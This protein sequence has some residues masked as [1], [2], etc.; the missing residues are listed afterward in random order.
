MFRQYL[1]RRLSRA[2][3]LT[4][5]MVVM[6]LGAWDMALAQVGATGSLGGVVQD[7]SGAALPGVTVT[8]KS[9][10]GVER[11]VQTDSNGRWLIPVLPTGLYQI[12]YRRDGFRELDRRGV[13]VEA[14]V[15]RTIDVKLETG[16][17]T[18]TITITEDVPLQVVTTTAATFRQI[19]AEQ[20]TKVPTS[21]RSFT[22]LLSTEA[23]VAADLPPVSTNGNGNVSPA[24]NGTRTTSTSLQFNG[25]DATNIT[26]NEG[27]LDGNISPAPETLSEVKLQTSLYDASTGRSGGG[28]FQ[29][30]TKSG[31][32]EFHGVG[33]HYIQNEIFNANDFFFNRDGIERP[34]ARRNEGGFAI[35][36]PIRKD[37]LFFFGGYQRTQASTAF[38]P[39]ASSITVLPQF[40]AL[41]G[42]DRSAARI[43]AAVNQLN[44][45]LNLLPSEI[46]P[47][48]LNLLNR[49]NPVTGGF[50]IPTPGP[51]AR[52]I[53]TDSG[54]GL[55]GLPVNVTGNSV[56]VTFTNSATGTTRNVNTGS[57]GGTRGNPMLQERIVQPANFTQDQ[58]N[59]RVDWQIANNN[60]LSGVFFFADFPG[61][62]PFTSPTNLASPATIRRADQNYSVAI[63]DV[64]TFSPTLINEFR[65]GYFRLRNS[66]ALD[67]PLLVQ[68]DEI[69]RTFN[70]SSLQAFNPSSIFDSGTNSFR[71]PRI[72]T[73]A[74]NFSINGPNDAFNKRLQNTYSLF[75]T[76]TWVKGDQTFRFGAEF[77]RHFFDTDL[78]EEQGV[79]FEKL[80][81][82][83]QFLAGRV[84]E[85][86]TQY[87]FTQKNFR[88]FDVSLFAAADWRL[89]NNFTLNYGVR[90][91]YF[92]TPSEKRGRFGNFYPDLVTDPNNIITGFVVPSNAKPTGFAAID[93]SI[94]RSV[95][96]NSRSTINDDRNNFAPR[97]GFA[98]T[99]FDSGRFVV[100][101]GYGFFYD[102]PSAAFIN[103]VFSNYPFLREIEVT[104]PAGNVPFTTAF[105]QQDPNRPFFQFVTGIPAQGI[106]GLRVVRT[107][108][109]TGS[110]QIRDGT[111]VTRQADG[112]LN[113]IDPA[114]GQPFFGNVAETFEFRA[115]DRRLRTPYIQQWN[116][117]VQYELRKNWI[118]E[119]RY[120][121]TKGTKLLQAL[122]LN[123]VFDMNDPSTPDLIYERFNRAYVAAG[124]PN[125]PLNPGATARERGMGRAF[126]FPNVA[127]PVGDPRRTMDLNVA[128]AAGSVLPFEAR[129]FYLGLNIPEAILL[130]SSA[131]SIYHSLQLTTQQRLGFNE[132]YGGLSYFAA[133][134]WSKSI[135]NMS[136]DPGST[137]GNARPDAPN[138][139]FV[140]Q[141]D[142]R[143]LRANRGPS[144]FDRTHRFSATV[145]Y[146]FPTFG[147]NNR[148]V[149]GW[150]FSTFI[151]VQSGAPFSIFSSEP[152]ISS[153]GTNGANFTSLRL[154]SGGLF[155][156]GFGRPNLAPGAT[157]SD[158]RRRGPEPTEQFFN[159]AALASPLGGYGNLG[160]NVLRGPFQKRVDFSLAKNTSITERVGIEFRWDIFNVFNNVNFALPGNDL[161][162]SGDFGT[163][164]NTVGGPR[165]MQFSLKVRF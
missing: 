108:G 128:N 61:F 114:T 109:A 165:I 93:T 156:P 100:R 113:P 8:V 126:G 15:P 53:G 56:T 105:S 14:A 40:L 34:R 49:R 118:V 112:S 130:T 7:A 78:P 29:L 117:G 154:G 17:V 42:S 43:A 51:N 151:Q 119:A 88:F 125:G 122:I 35:G 152:E 27:S 121:G 31:T 45:G 80:E 115:V 92:G 47:V 90:Y 146:D 133:Y 120:I 85:A 97:I 94:D 28:N 164:T 26:S 159:P 132:S 87:G 143:N 144:D 102:R 39:T 99:P 19:N 104:A 101:G 103:T 98:W 18:E 72:V 3:C 141:G 74:S 75:D 139:G 150:A 149:K 89:T 73:R 107:A 37:R 153:V 95:R 158:L 11:T 20:L 161:Q 91:E 96:A 77:K 65:F 55:P 123:T 138:V 137:A 127:F 22:H 2:L 10:A 44:P 16:A 147:V 106:P 38:V 25:I 64:H 23:G 52:L 59:S 136:A 148:F 86:D 68:P 66:R 160:R 58:V 145:V 155:R 24:V 21:T 46:S 32:N 30:V 9:D 13:E 81:N 116:L 62:D 140:A 142:P 70:A 110:Y 67:T 162:D 6:A 69:A 50:L 83:T 135:D 33:Y 134:T 5:G 82:F 4:I 54:T 1:P 163:I 111:G 131:S 48:A 79:E 76:L 129:G 36:G 157:I 60:R 71:L 12:S 84:T 63:S 124:S 41:V 57:A